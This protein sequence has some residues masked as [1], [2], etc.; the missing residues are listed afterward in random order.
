MDPALSLFRLS[1]FLSVDVQHIWKNGNLCIINL[2]FSLR[3]SRSREQRARCQ[4]AT[5]ISPR[6][7]G[8]AGTICNAFLVVL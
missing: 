3:K 1:Y 8:F 7:R 6:E 5:R 2:K 4:V